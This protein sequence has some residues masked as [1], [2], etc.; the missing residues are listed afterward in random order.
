MAKTKVCIII[1]PISGT[2]SKQSIPETIAAAF[3]Q[4]KFDVI[5]R[6]TGYPGHATEIAKDAVAEKFTY[7]ICAGGDGTVNEVAKALVNTDCTLGIIPF[8]SGNGLARE[9]GIPMNTKGAID[10]IRKEKCRKID[11]GIANGHIFFTT[12]GVGFD[13]FIS[14]RFAE[15]K[16]RGALGYLRNI[17]E[18]V[19]DFKAESY[20]IEHDEGVI[21]E[22]A[23]VVTC[24]NASQYGNDMFIAPGADMED[25]KMNLS[26][27]K[28]FNALEIPQTTL[29]LF[30]NNID[31]NGK[32]ISLLT[33]NVV[34]K[35]AHSGTMHV[36]GEPI[37][38]G[39]TITVKMIKRGLSVLAPQKSRKRSPKDTNI[40]SALTRWIGEQ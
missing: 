21:S 36:D 37:E 5:I 40:F 11:Y 15:D 22:K 23:F 3:D 35:R 20:E 25:G 31:K 6:I 2:E 26:I 34:I 7:V 29:Q 13:A 10:I 19:F 38:T 33:E 16:Q 27:L 30:T 39:E 4:K 24:A 14:N 32:M 12:C 18:G 8:G 1:N 17:L 9:L 28:P